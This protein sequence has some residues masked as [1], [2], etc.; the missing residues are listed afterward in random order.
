MPFD[1]IKKALE[2]T[3]DEAVKDAADNESFH[4]DTRQAAREI[5][6][7]RGEKKNEEK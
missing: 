4:P 1:R 2:K 5:L 3:S 6:A 7:K